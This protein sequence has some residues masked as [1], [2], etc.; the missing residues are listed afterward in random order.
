MHPATEFGIFVFKKVYEY[1]CNEENYRGKPGMA[2]EKGTWSSYVAKE[3][4]YH[5]V[6]REVACYLIK[7]YQ[8]QTTKAARCALSL[9]TQVLI[10]EHFFGGKLGG[11]FVRDL[12]QKIEVYSKEIDEE[13]ELFYRP[14]YFAEKEALIQALSLSE[15]YLKEEKGRGDNQ[16]KP[17]SYAFHIVGTA[18][19]TIG[20][21]IL[22]KKKDEEEKKRYAH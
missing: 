6:Y 11:D 18:C 20:A 9:A 14:L 10:P 2:T 8:A 15:E 22:F 5:I 16:M 17:F 21:K 12:H 13:I 4:A 1:L 3:E 7:K 19:A